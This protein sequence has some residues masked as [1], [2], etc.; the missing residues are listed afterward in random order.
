MFPKLDGIDHIHVYV[1][2]REA[3]A[4]WYEKY[5][6][7][8]VNATFK[9][10]AEDEHGPLTIEDPAGQIHLALFK[11]ENLTPS[12]AIAFKTDGSGFLGWK[13]HLEE[14]NLILRCSDHT[15]SWSLYFNDLDGNM[16]EITTYDHDFVSGQL[17]SE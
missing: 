12:T 7:F 10:W 9:F 5:L 17:K 16:H 6:G 11:T 4:N 1:S 14:A 8:K 2:D 3:A 15:K 13:S